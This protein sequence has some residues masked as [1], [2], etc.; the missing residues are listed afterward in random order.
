M[1]ITKACNNSHATTL[2]WRLTE[3]V[4]NST[5]LGKYESKIKKCKVRIGGWVNHLESLG[6]NFKK[7]RK[8]IN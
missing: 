3:L 7:S 1:K 5:T 8:K 6:R 4:A 2:I